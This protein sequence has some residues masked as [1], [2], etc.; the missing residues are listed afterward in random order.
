MSMRNNMNFRLFLSLLPNEEWR[1]YLTALI[2]QLRKETGSSLI[3]WIAPENLHITLRFI[4]ECSRERF[5]LIQPLLTETI[6]VIAPFSLSANNI[7]LFP[8]PSHAHTIALGI[9]L[10]SALFELQQVIDHAVLSIGFASDKYEFLPHITLGRISADPA[11]NDTME[12][13]QKRNAAPLHP[14][15]SPLNVQEVFLMNSTS[16]HGK[17]IYTILHQFNLSG[18][19]K[20]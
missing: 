3:H 11:E 6:K 9:K 4:G 7:Q 1:Q 10:N 18:I 20:N 17:R 8:K 12:F 13:L 2:Q 16:E 19:A 14:Q 5:P 15:L